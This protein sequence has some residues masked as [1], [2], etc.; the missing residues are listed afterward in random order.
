MGLFKDL[1]DQPSNALLGTDLQFIDADTLHGPDDQKYRLPSVNAPETEKVVRGEYKKGTAGGQAF[2]QASIKLANDLGFTNLKP[3][4][5]DDGKPL[6]D[7]YGR[8]LADLYD[9]SGQAFSNKLIEE[10]I[11]D[12]TKYSSDSDFLAS[13]IGQLRRDQEQVA[14]TYEPDEWDQARDFVTSA[15]IAEGEKQLG[16][17]KTALN[18]IELAAAKE[19]GYGDHYDTSSVQFRSSDR[20]LDNQAL[21]PWSDSWSSG[22]QSVGESFYGVANLIG[23]ETGLEG[24]ADWGA[25][26]VDKQQVKQQQYAQRLTDW[27]E[28]DGVW[29]FV[30]YIGNQAAQSLPYMAVT[31]GATAAAPLTGG[32]SFAA[33]VSL[34]TGMTWNEMEGE[35]NAGIAVAGGVAQA[36]LDRLGLGGVFKA[37]VAPKKLM[38]EAIEKLVKEGTPR[39]QA[40]EL[41]ANAT[42][43]TVGELAKDISGFAAKQ[44]KAK[45]LVKSYLSRAGVG[46][47]SEA[48]TEA[49]QEAIGYTAATQGSDKQFDWTELQD[50]MIAGAIAGGTLGAG[51]TLPGAVSEHAKLIDQ[52]VR[53]STDVENSASFAEKYRQEEIEKNGEIASIK[54]ITADARERA[55]ANPAGMVNLNDRVDAGNQLR[56]SKSRSDWLIDEALN[57]KQWFVGSTANI[58]DKDLQTR[59]ST[60]RKLADTFGANLQRVFSGSRVPPAIAPAII[61][62]CN[63]VQSNC[64]SDP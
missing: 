11:S 57:V 54:E 29:D 22:W 40:Q 28:I 61:L 38:N 37:G 64:L 41:V 13:E 1:V 42:K 10:G 20:T 52:K 14:G 50:R 60:A 30:D 4:L 31:A 45:E 19:Y 27:K 62:S 43:T 58:F 47:G 7:H 44:L 24:L 23:T 21:N 25:Q 34:Y 17:R 8:T 18:E 5:D 32:A 56:D 3:R 6:L 46:A 15:A 55:Q 59:S 9:S 33:P 26:G 39:G 49:A 51:F 63:S 53:G 12:P 2:T 36:A 16:F 48:I 35:K